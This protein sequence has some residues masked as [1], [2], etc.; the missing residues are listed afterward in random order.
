[1]ERAYELVVRW[2]RRDRES[3]ISS[4]G[5]IKHVSLVDTTLNEKYSVSRTVLEINL[6]TVLI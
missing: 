3:Y 4:I 6:Q 2:S 1:M 5:W